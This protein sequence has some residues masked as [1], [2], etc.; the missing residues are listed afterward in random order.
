MALDPGSGA[1][2]IPNMTDRRQAP[3]DA[4]ALLD[5]AHQIG[6][7]RIVDFR[8]G[9]RQFWL[10][11]PERLG[12]LRRLQ[13]GGSA[14]AFRREIHMLKAFRAQGAP[15]VPI[16]AEEPDLVIL[17]DMGPALNVLAITVPD[18][19]FAMR[20]ADAARALADLHAKGMAHGRPRLRDICWTGTG[21]C[22]LDLEA[23]AKLGAQPEARALDLL[24]FLHSILYQD[25]AYQRHLPA[26][27]HAYRAGDRAGIAQRALHLVRR[28]RPVRPVF[29]LLARRDRKRGK[30]RSEAIAALSLFDLYPKLLAAVTK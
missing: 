18:D 12:L 24:L 27:L 8:L 25:T 10:K 16:L 5:H 3:P 30:S 29:A 1:R 14:R 11:R 2:H 9:G 7:G 4:Q 13:K 21:I 17:P 23:G 15:V 26:C 28:L 19:E 22:F 20:L 6:A